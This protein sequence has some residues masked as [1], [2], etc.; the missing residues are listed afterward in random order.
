MPE[1]LTPHEEAELAAF[2]SQLERGRNAVRDSDPR[3]REL[4]WM[5]VGNVLL[6][7]PVLCFVAIVLQDP[8]M[9]DNARVAAVYTSIAGLVLAAWGSL[10]ALYAVLT[11]SDS[12]REA[13]ILYLFSF[14]LMFALFFF[15]FGL[16]IGWFNTGGTGMRR[17]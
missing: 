15:I 4:R 11:A 6:L 3:R 13:R 16:F 8:V 7:L 12:E 10:R 5:L 17:K 14:L 9:R 1:P 2:N